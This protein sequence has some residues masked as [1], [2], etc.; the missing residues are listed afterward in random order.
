MKKVSRA[1]AAAALLAAASQAA[2][3]PSTVWWTPA[4]TYVQPYLVPHLTYDTYFGEGGAYPI[5]SGVQIGILPFEKLQAEIGFD[6]NYPGYTKNGLLFNAK[7]G[8]PEGAFGDWFPGISAGI[9][10]LGLKKDVSDYNILHAEIGKTLGAFGT[11][12]L[13]GYF[14]N[15]K[16]LLDE[17]GAKANS[18]FMA[19]YV[20]PD[21]AVGLPGLTKINFFGDVQTG[22]SAFGAWGLGIGLYFTPAIDLLAGPVFF[23]NEKVQ[24]GQSKMMWS[25]QIDVDVELLAKPKS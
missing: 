6:L 3:T 14:G 7:L 12:T 10:G 21:V 11:L 13:G 20:T 1:L 5:D 23:L 24:P 8:V 15:D 18:G 16:L 22:K 9:Y 4:T 25:L 17:T 2:A 19:A